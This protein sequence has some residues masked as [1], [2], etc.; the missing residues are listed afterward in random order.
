MNRNVSTNIVS[1]QT[2]ANSDVMT[3]AQRWRVAVPVVMGRRYDRRAP[4]HM[5]M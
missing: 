3:K 4:S 1:N 5:S 2:A